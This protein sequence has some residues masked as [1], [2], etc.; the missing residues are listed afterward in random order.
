MSARVEDNRGHFAVDRRAPAE[1]YLRSGQAASRV[2]C[3]Q[4][5]SNQS[6]S[7]GRTIEC[8]ERL[9]YLC[10]IDM[11]LCSGSG[12]VGRQKVWLSDNNLFP[13]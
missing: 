7:D 13:E 8:Q 6:Q 11:R 4:G 10:T 1:Q 12:T 5:K 2:E 9:R 3:S